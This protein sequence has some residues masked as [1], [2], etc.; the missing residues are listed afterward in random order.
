MRGLGVPGSG[1]SRLRLALNG[2]PFRVPAIVPLTPGVA[3]AVS[4]AVPP[5]THER[6]PSIRCAPPASVPG[7]RRSFP[8]SVRWRLLTLTNWPDCWMSNW[9]PE[10]TGWT[11]AVAGSG[12]EAGAVGVGPMHGFGPRVS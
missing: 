10:A 11:G 9:G 3:S 12:A 5:L 8:L 2:A 1:G 6:F 7:W 4:L